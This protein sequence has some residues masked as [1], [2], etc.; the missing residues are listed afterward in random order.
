MSLRKQNSPVFIIGT[1]RSG[2]HWLAHTFES[3]DEI[4]CTIEKSPMFELSK[5]ISLNQENE[6][7]AYIKL[8]NAYKFE[9]AKAS[10]KIYLDKSHPNIWIAERLKK[11]FSQAMFIG[12]ERNVYATVASMLKHERVLS[13]H[14]TWSDYSIPNRFL[15]IT[16]E[17]AKIYSNMSLASKCALRWLSHKIRMNKLKEN[18]GVSIKV[19]AFEELASKTPVVVNELQEFLGLQNP[20]KAP[21]VQSD[22]VEK[23]KRQLSDL[24]VSQIDSVIKGYSTILSEMEENRW[25]NK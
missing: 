8:V 9:I 4:I 3:S 18:L 2:T 17:I 25:R 19:I 12:I 24:H 15:G 23:W 16:I 20:L 5:Y 11:S 7:K 14:S 6:N 22:S 1:G 10:S 21:E 13:W